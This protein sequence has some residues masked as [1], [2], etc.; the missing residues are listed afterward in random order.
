MSFIIPPPLKIEFPEQVAL[1]DSIGGSRPDVAASEKA[2]NELRQLIFAEMDI[3]KLYK[4]GDI[5]IH[6]G[7]LDD[8]PA[9]W[10]LAT[11]MMDRAVVGAGNQYAKGQQ[12]GADSRGTQARTLSVNQMAHHG[13]NGNNGSLV[14]NNFKGSDGPIDA[15]ARV[16]RYDRD[17]V[18][19]TGAGGNWA[20]DHGAIDTRQQ[21]I[22]VIWIRKL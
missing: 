22:A 17:L 10:E 12:F 13:H 3:D 19:E 5:K 15:S 6:R 9:G 8:I 11:D 18:A 21:S 1:S 14:S 16:S 2:V 4:S 7:T 20:H